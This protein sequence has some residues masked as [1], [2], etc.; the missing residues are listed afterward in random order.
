MNTIKIKVGRVINVYGLIIG[1]INQILI[2]IKG[3]IFKVEKIGSVI[4]IFK[5]SINSIEET[6]I[7]WLGI[8]AEK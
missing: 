5:I 3:F 7:N 6:G 2:L 4:N 1:L 8:K